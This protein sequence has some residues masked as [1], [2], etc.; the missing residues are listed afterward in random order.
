MESDSVLNKKLSKSNFFLKKQSFW[1]KSKKLKNYQN[2]FKS[3]KKNFDKAKL[4]A[5]SITKTITRAIG[6]PNPNNRKA[7]SYLRQVFIK[8]LILQYFNL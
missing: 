4:L 2:L 1:T 8:A 3:Q 5:N 7:F 6:Y